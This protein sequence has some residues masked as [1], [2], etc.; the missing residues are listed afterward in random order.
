MTKYVERNL[1]KNE[2]IVKQAK[3]TIAFLVITW[4][5][6]ILFC[7]FFLIPLFKA[8]Q[9]TIKHFR[10]ELAVTNKKVLGRVGVFNTKALDA[11]LS[12]IQSISVTQP[13]FGKICNYG[14]VRVSTAAGDFIFE[15]IA[16]PDA[17][18]GIVMA[19]IDQYEEDRIK[20]QAAEMAGAMAEAIKS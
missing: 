18:K 3:L 1:G 12:K 10:T 17:F 13:F 15:A 19:Q 5:K 2:T 14:T 4:L 6:G 16:A 8:I 9:A 20:Q 11:P 7:W